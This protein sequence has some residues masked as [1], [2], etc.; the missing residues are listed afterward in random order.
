MIQITGSGGPLCDGIDRRDFLKLGAFGATAGLTLPNL[1]RADAKASASGGKRKGKAKS[2]ILF[3]LV[4]GQSQLDTFDMKPG[5]PDKIR[6]E[7][8]PIRSATPGLQVC[9]H[10]PELAKRTGDFALIRSMT[11]RASNHN[12]GMYYALSGVAPAR[13]VVALSTGPDDFPNPGAIISKFN[14]TTRKVPSFVQMS[15]AVVGDAYSQVPGQNAGFLG[16][17][18]DPFKVTANPADEGFSVEELALPANVSNARFERRRSLLKT[19]EEQFPLIGE[20]PEIGRMDTFYQRAYSLVTSPEAREAFDLKRES[21]KTRDRYGR[22]SFGQQLLLAR[23]LVEAGVRITTV[24]WG[25]LLNAPDD[26]WDTHTGNFTKQKENLLPKFDQCFSALLDDLKDRGMLDDTLVIAMGEFGRTPRIGVVTANAGTDASGRD[27]WPQCYHLLMAGGGVT[28][29]A[30]IGKSDQYAAYPVEKA[31]TPEDL[32]ATIYYALG[33][34]WEA[35]IHDRLNRPLP[36]TRGQPI[37]DFF[38]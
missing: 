19:V 38:A 12:P 29:G 22:F 10:L 3:F 6:G 37:M 4:G 23:R 8:K 9:E 14:P 15:P 21:D 24:Y 25:G 2:V 35:E 20:S 5:A 31:A 28:A 32:I 16:S 7:F 11:H 18:F 33:M 1:L 17:K 36:V 27:H 30:V 13:D 26:Y 34:N